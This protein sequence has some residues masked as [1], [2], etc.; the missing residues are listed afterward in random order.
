MWHAAEG[1]DL[2]QKGNERHPRTASGTQESAPPARGAQMFR[3]RGL[4]RATVRRATERQGHS[5][6]RAA[7]PRQLADRSCPCPCPCRPL[8]AGRA[9]DGRA[10]GGARRHGRVPH[11]G[12]CLGLTRCT[13]LMETELSMS[14][15]EQGARPS[16]GGRASA[17]HRGSEQAGASST[18]SRRA[19]RAVYAPHAFSRSLASA[20]AALLWPL[21]RG[22]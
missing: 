12:P 9:H 13:S 14:E 19:S 7:V 18:R 17:V 16:H 1:P 3:R 2:E 8:A 15:G 5:R 10:G 6:I 20:V 11:R 4:E 22:R 21:R